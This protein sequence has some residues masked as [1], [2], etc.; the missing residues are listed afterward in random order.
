M[1]SMD[2]TYPAGFAMSTVAVGAGNSLQIGDRT[3]IYG[4]GGAKPGAATN[5]GSGAL[6]LGNDTTVGILASDGSIR[7][8]D[9]AHATSLLAAGAVT[10]GNQ[11]VIGGETSGA[12]LTPLVHRTLDFLSATGA[13]SAVTLQPSQSASPPPGIYASF[14]VASRASL[15]LT[16]GNY[17]LNSLDVEPQATV[18]LDTSQGTIHIYVANSWIWHAATILGDTSQLVVE[19]LGSSEMSLE[20][21]F[22]GTVL[23]PHATLN[24]ATVQGTYSGT[25]Y[26]KDVVIQPGVTILE[27]PPPML[28]DTVTVSNT[29]PCVG[30]ETEVTASVPNAGPGVTTWINGVIGS[31]QILQFSGY[32][33]P[34][35]IVVTVYTAD[36]KADSSVTTINVQQCPVTGAPQAI[37]HFRPTTSGP[38]HVEFM[39]HFLDS[40]GHE[41]L[42]TGP[43]HY[44]WVFG[45]GTTAAGSSPLIDHDYSAAMHPLDAVTNF[46]A[47]VTVIT[48]TGSAT[49]TK[50][51]PIWSLYAFNRGKRI[52]QPTSV[53]TKSASTGLA[54]QVANSE[55]SPIT[56]TQAMVELIPCDP[57][58]GVRPQG[59]QSV[60]VTIPPSATANVPVVEPTSYPSDVCAMAV[61]LQGTASAG[62]VLTDAYARLVTENPVLRQSITDPATI[63][64][65][66]QASQHTSDPHQF[67]EQELRQLAA[68]GT[69]RQLPT[70]APAAGVAH[71]AEYTLAGVECVP[72]ATMSGYDCVATA[73]W[74]ANPAEALNANNGN[75]IMDHGCGT[76]G[77]LLA[78]VGDLYS[79]T[80]TV[81]QNRVAVR[82][83]TAASDRINDSLGCQPSFGVVPCTIALDPVKV[84]YAFPGSYGAATYTID[85]MVTQYCVPDP[86]SDSANQNERICDSTGNNCDCP[87]GTWRMGGEL[88]PNPINICTGDITST[89]P[90]VVKPMTGSTVSLQGVANQAMAL[91]A[92]YRF[93]MYS[94]SDL[95]ALAPAPG[96]GVNTPA[97]AAGTESTQCS[98]FDTLSAEHTGGLNL[99]P[100][101]SP[102]E[103]VPDGMRSYTTN[104]RGAGARALFSLVRQ[105]GIDQCKDDANGVGTDVI[106]GLES[107]VCSAIGDGIGNQMTNCFANDACSDTNGDW[108]NVQPG[109]AVSPDDILH[110][111]PLSTKVGV[112]SGTYGYNEP[113]VY[114]PYSFRHKYVWQP[115]STSGSILVHVVDTTGADVPDASVLLDTVTMG[116]TGSDGTLLIPAAAAGLHTVEA[117][118]Y[119]GPTLPPQNPPQPVSGSDILNLPTCPATPACQA[120]GNEAPPDGTICPSG[121]ITGASTSANCVTSDYNNS[122]EGDQELTY[123]DSIYACYPTP[124]PVSCDF[125]W[126][127]ND[128]TVVSNSQ[129]S[130]ELTLCNSSCLDAGT[131]TTPQQCPTYCQHPSDCPTGLTCNPAA[132]A[133]AD[134]GTAGTVCG[135]PPEKLHIVSDNG[136]F[137]Q[138]YVFNANQAT[139]QASFSIDL[140]CDPDG[141]GF[142]QQVPE[143]VWSG[144][145]A[146]S[147]ESADQFNFSVTC[148]RDPNSPGIHATMTLV[149]YQN[150]SSNL[151]WE[152]QAQWEVDVT[153]TEPATNNVSPAVCFDPGDWCISCPDP[154]TRNKGQVTATYSVIQS[155]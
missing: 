51:V 36:G 52:V 9:R 98:L 133:G 64:I 117:Q 66:N 150:C 31:Q 116:G 17:I 108:T 110:W 136:F 97:W 62:V 140:I 145:N 5:S 87:K 8:S 118:R 47:S 121:W 33:G 48:L 94:R 115:Q 100:S 30:Q 125:V 32:P 63:A 50:V 19:Y 102:L 65:L 10:L 135:P 16:A 55:P 137:T 22:G 86:G 58:L 89:P 7:V 73:D 101:V 114:L 54:L 139:Y 74:V 132:D 45:D 109:V 49:V 96:Y 38:N 39:V 104:E 77:Q 53:L 131:G 69:I 56:I 76:I 144:S 105:R 149:G 122:G 28:I 99:W 68:Q 129:V 95:A 23:A 12:I 79:H 123:C 20:A 138:L 25:Y 151:S 155:N 41:Q 85:Q 34:H 71:P 70:I 11:D 60:S 92:H 120:D 3:K 35:D 107:A 46:S 152:N 37:L 91:N 13:A 82:H 27:V 148:Q 40:Y 126:A 78:A 142:A 57:S 154:C 106:P 93:W 26:G 29:S 14:S 42:P 83:S 1:V 61:H 141:S 124:P 128:V 88:N 67:G 75:F 72:G 43:A 4:V 143:C 24:F 103:N 130:R 90:V 112:P 15:N 18:N 113:L 119:T 6:S 81:V 127:Q 21:P 44:S 134:A 153:P 59:A 111:D 146:T 147:G 2:V 80:S 84:Q